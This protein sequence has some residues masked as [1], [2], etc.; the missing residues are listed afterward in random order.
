MKSRPTMLSKEGK[1]CGSQDHSIVSRPRDTSTP[2]R[3]SKGADGIQHGPLPVITRSL[4]RP[5]YQNIG[6]FPRSF[7]KNT[8]SV[9]SKTFSQKTVSKQ[10]SHD[11]TEFP[12]TPVCSFHFIPPCVVCVR[13]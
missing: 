8:T 7:Q 13:S 10:A 12:K 11:T 1:H 4:K 5:L 2:A 6:P 3:R 9:L